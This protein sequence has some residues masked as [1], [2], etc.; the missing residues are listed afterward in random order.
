MSKRFLRNLRCHPSRSDRSSSPRRRLREVRSSGRPTKRMFSRFTSSSRWMINWT[1][2]L[3]TYG[4]NCS[5]NASLFESWGEKVQFVP[6]SLVCEIN[7]FRASHDSEHRKLKNE[8][9]KLLEVVG[10][11]K[12]TA[13]STANKHLAEIARLSEEIATLKEGKSL[14]EK[15]TRCCTCASV[16]KG[17]AKTGDSKVDQ[18]TATAK[19]EIQK[20]VRRR[21]VWSRTRKRKILLSLQLDELK[22]KDREIFA[23]KSDWKKKESQVSS[24]QSIQSIHGAGK[25]SRS[26]HSWA[27]DNL[28]PALFSYVAPFAVRLRSLR[29]FP[30]RCLEV[31]RKRAKKPA[32][33]KLKTLRSL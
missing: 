29:I 28:S 9:K 3:A 15:K 13:A 16:L 7:F 6:H 10:N 32:K 8:T 12:K 30:F 1:S 26:F 27:N 20:L 25:Q 31:S 17:M 11:V 33:Q 4:S 24:T 19:A 22:S 14:L 23:L 18:I 2:R 5:M 21:F